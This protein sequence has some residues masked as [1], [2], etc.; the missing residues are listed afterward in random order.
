[1]N[2]ILIY[3]IN[4]YQKIPGDFHKKCRYTPTCSEYMKIAINEYGTA[5]GFL[6]GIKRILRC[7]PWGGYG[8]DPVPGKGRRK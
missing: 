6:L 3:L 7:N 4:L 2:R 1:M 8:Y 5:K